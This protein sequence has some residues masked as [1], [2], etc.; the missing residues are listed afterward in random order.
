MPSPRTNPSNLP[1]TWPD[2][3]NLT[4]RSLNSLIDNPFNRPGA[5]CRTNATASQSNVTTNSLYP[6]RG[7]QGRTFR[8]T[9]YART[10]QSTCS[11]LGSHSGTEA[12]STHS[13]PSW[14]CW[15][16]THIV[17]TKKIIL[18]I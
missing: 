7:G 9:Q 17:V 3:C 13:L 18:T 11:F 16:I 4:T 5:R 15:C 10:S 1:T 14:S 2:D 8:C 6:G 12:R